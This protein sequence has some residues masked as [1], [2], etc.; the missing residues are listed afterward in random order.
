MRV[1][2]ARKPIKFGYRKSVR[3]IS[4][5][6]DIEIDAKEGFGMLCQCALPDQIVVDGEDVMLKIF[7]FDGEDFEIGLMDRIQN[8][9]LGT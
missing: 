5:R 9:V 6:T 2:Y 8:R 1:I 7:V 4:P 3:P